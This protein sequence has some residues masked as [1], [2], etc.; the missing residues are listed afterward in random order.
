MALQGPPELCRDPV[1]LYLGH[2]WSG[3]R[4]LSLGKPC[5]S[6]APLTPAGPHSL[7]GPD[8]THRTIPAEPSACTWGLPQAEHIL[9]LQ[10][11]AALVPLL[12]PLC[13]PPR[14]NHTPS[15]L[16][17]SLAKES[18]DIQTQIIDDLS[19]SYEALL[20]VISSLSLRDGLLPTPGPCL[21]LGLRR[22][23]KQCPQPSWGPSHWTSGATTEFIVHT[24]THT[25]T[26]MHTTL[27]FAIFLGYFMN[28]L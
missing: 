12:R 6:R 2:V 9:S 20:T 13:S 7:H 28:L 10:R 23:P 8:H 22:I 27:Y 5:A 18:R 16:E 19:V 26:C 21:Q 15:A 1:G 17:F 25:H 11:G 3:A 14:G 24:R 4:P